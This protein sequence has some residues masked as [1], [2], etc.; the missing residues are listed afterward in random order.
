MNNI[1][2]NIRNAIIIGMAFILAL[3]LGV[4]IV[5]AQTE[6]ALQFSGAALL[7]VCLF[8]GRRIW[9]LMILF[10]A[11]SVPLIRGFN[12]TELG[13]ALFIGFTLVIFLLR[14]QPLKVKFGELEFW[15]LLVAASV[16]QVY[17]RNPVGLNMFGAGAV[18]AKPYFMVAMA[19][20]TGIILGCIVVPPAEI[21]WYLRLT[22]IGSFLGIGLTALRMRGGESTGFVKGAKLDDARASGRIGSLGSIGL[23]LSRVLASYLSPLQALLHPGWGFLILLT[24]A[25]AAGSGFR[26]G[27]ASVGMLYLVAIAYRSGLPGVL[28]SILIG[29]MGLGLLAIVNVAMPLPP[30]V[31][32][33]LS[34][35]PG[36]WEQRYIDAA[37]SSTE[38]RVEMWKEA[39]F[40]PYWID[41]KILGDGLGFSR[42]EMKILE[43][44]EAGGAGT[45]SLGSGMSMQQESMMITAGYHSGP[46]Q[47][48]RIT[49]YVGLLILLVTMIR[50]AVHA[51]RQILRCRG[52]EWLPV[53]MFTGLPA[54]SLPFIYVFVFGDFG[55]DVSAVCFFYGMVRLLEKNLPLPAF[56]KRRYEPF[57]LKRGHLSGPSSAPPRAIS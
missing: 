35:F 5:T 39:L 9:L 2:A 16:V 10:S 37:E 7:L 28:F 12:T 15:M 4:S 22:I 57:I 52:T 1:S 32:R 23:N 43:A 20:T 51:H 56:V 6:T 36:T 55:R 47:C 25:A 42:R 54:I 33:A 49:G 45:G 18:G 14:R 8:L 46:V 31:Q 19:F 27:V 38:W 21:K 50:V 48:I 44:V 53:A 29:S 40:T 13:Q 34:P 41:N 17:L 24:V 11:L 3:W 30:N 26:N